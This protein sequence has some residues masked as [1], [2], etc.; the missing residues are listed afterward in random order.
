MAINELY[1]TE[2]HSVARAI[3]DRAGDVI[4]SVRSADGRVTHFT[5]GSCAVINIGSR[6]LEQADPEDY[7]AA[8]QTGSWLEN[9]HLLPIIPTLWKLVPVQPSNGQ[10]EVLSDLIAWAD[11]IFHVGDP[12]REGQL[13]ID[14]ILRYLNNTK[15]VKRILPTA[16]DVVSL[17]RLIKD[18]IDNEEYIGLYKSGLG[19][20]RADWLFG[21]NGTRACSIANQKNGLRGILSTGRVQTPAL[22]MVVRRD[23]QIESF[24]SHTYFDLTGVFGSAEGKCNAKWVSPVGVAGLDVDG[25]LVDVATASMIKAKCEGRQAQVISVSVED[26]ILAPPMP[27]ALIG[28]QQ[29]AAEL[30]GM[31]ARRVMDICQALYDRR[32]TS[33]AKS[34][35]EY[36]PEELF[37]ESA[38][39]VT[40]LARR[41]P[42]IARVLAGVDFS[43]KSP[44]WSSKKAPTY[45]G[46][47]PTGE[48]DGVSLSP[49]EQ[50]IFSLI[51]MN[52]I[53]QFHPDCHYQKRTAIIAC[54]GIK[55]SSYMEITMIDGWRALFPDI[56]CVESF[57]ET[58]FA[59]TL[60]P[61]M[62]LPCIKVA[63]N[64]LHTVAPLRYTELTLV[65]GMVNVYEQVSDPEIRKKLKEVRGIGTVATRPEIIETLARRKFVAVSAQTGEI[66]STP[67]G[68][69]F[70]KTLPKDFTNVTLTALWEGALDQ[71]ERSAM[72]LERF[73]DG[74]V[75]WIRKLTRQAL[76]MKMTVAV[77]LD[78]ENVAQAVLE[79]VGKTCVVCEKGFMRLVES[80]GADSKTGYFLGCSN[81]PNCKNTADIEGQDIAKKKARKSKK[82]SAQSDEDGNLAG[83]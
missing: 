73:M 61:K 29:K 75:Q 79:R 53:A 82:K 80:K 7:D 67:A 36:L 59:A 78:D 81:F 18:A 42:E 62:I 70:I 21:I 83:Q 22:A 19:R 43:R 41:D 32:M 66:A 68:R 8:F 17:E 39:I 9:A 58:R 76:E 25:R 13:L 16:I 11:K 1:I 77:G 60:V 40:A 63:A 50:K 45:H 47:I 15:P 48:V 27:F 64:K 44:S 5:A 2:R 12:D 10:L 33:H 3:V 74:Q 28:L 54:D 51:A 38:R 49:D 65:Q 72:T 56:A 24:V 31:E 26:K 34:D 35:C 30:Y 57:M 4:N 69:A 23:A 71:I 14:E 37:G 52:F 46:I 20:Q 55:F 6:L